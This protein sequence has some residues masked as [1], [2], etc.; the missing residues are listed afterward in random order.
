MDQS[1]VKTLF[2][3][4]WWLFP[5]ATLGMT[6][7]LYRKHRRWAEA[8]KTQVEAEITGFD[9]SRD[10]DN[11]PS[12][13][14]IYRFRTSLGQTVEAKDMGSTVQPPSKGTKVQ[15]FYDREDPSQVSTREVLIP[16]WGWPILALADAAF[17]G[18]AWFVTSS[19]A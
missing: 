15:I 16:A 6:Y 5:A 19:M 7:Y 11:R 13:F 12:Y 3:A 18:L 14:P 1:L 4:I 9:V 10:D 8:P 2:Q 17:I